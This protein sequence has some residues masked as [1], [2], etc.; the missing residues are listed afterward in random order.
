MSNKKAQHGMLVGVDTVVDEARAAAALTAAIL[1]GR[2]PDIRGISSA[3]TAA[4][5]GGGCSGVSGSSFLKVSET[6][7]ES[8]CMAQ[9]KQKDI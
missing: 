5:G 4:G 9:Q 7:K 2:L 1:V 6:S 8:N 3:A